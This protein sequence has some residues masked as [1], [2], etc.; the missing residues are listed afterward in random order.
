MFKLWS[1]IQKD[2]RMLARDRV[3]LVFMFAM[4]IL[5]VIIVTSIQNSTFN[6]L[7]KNKISLIVNKPF[8]D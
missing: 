8:T 3:G 7:N 5:L 1:T 2:F 6:L 4:P